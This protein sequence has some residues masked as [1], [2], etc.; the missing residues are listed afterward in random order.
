M[1]RILIADDEPA[2][3]RILAVWLEARGHEVATVADGAAALAM[4]P[5]QGFDLIIA[6]IVMPVMDGIA[7][8]LA[9]AQVTSGVK[10]VLVT[11]Y[12]TELARARN[13]EALVERVVAKP[14]RLV[15]MSAIVDQLVGGVR[16]A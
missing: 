3:R 6:D 15:D 4:L 12:T 1:A 16:T 13:L 8:A 14:Y 5:A 7:L 9:A 10:L 11:G 2:E